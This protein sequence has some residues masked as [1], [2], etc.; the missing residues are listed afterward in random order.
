MKS[1]PLTIKEIQ[2]KKKNLRLAEQDKVNI[3]NLSQLQMVPIQLNGKNSNKA[4]NQITITIPPG[5]SA[6]LPKH[7]LMN[8]QISNLR[9]RGLIS[10]ENMSGNLTSYK[11][12]LKPSKINKNS[13]SD[14]TKSKIKH[15]K[16]KSK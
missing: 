3:V 12:F 6:K 2:E 5:K 1:R 9:K 7:R 4:I 10:V 8:D 16:D 15:N 14:K 13:N 11:D